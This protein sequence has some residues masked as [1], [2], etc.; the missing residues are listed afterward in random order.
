M[1]NKDRFF[2]LNDGDRVWWTVSGDRLGGQKFSFDK[3]KV[4][5][6]FKDYPEKLSV[7]E[8]LVFNAENEYWYNGFKDRNDAYEKKHRA[9]IDALVNG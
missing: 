8:W 5:D 6:L 3:K 7:E 2:K 1:P 9:E 4:Y